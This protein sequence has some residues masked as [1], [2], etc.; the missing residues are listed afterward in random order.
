MIKELK[1]IL[2]TAGVSFREVN[3]RIRLDLPNN[4][5]EL[6]IGELQDNDSIV[7]LVGYPWHTHGNLLMS[8][9]GSSEAEAIFSFLK[10]IA[11]GKLYLVELIKNG[12]TID[13]YISDS[14][15]AEYENRTE[16]EEIK[17]YNT[18]HNNLI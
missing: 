7:E 17:I 5:G 18:K 14:K 9:G 10:K 2:K 3:G 1:K 11:E 16:G 6:E 12:K 13:R 8:Y 15:E 4:F